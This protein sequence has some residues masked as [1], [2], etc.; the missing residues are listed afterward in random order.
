MNYALQH[1]SVKRLVALIDP[2]N[3]ASIRVATNTGMKFEKDV[4]LEGYDYPDHLY[5]VHFESAS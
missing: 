4:M 5:S 3:E 1:L 2:S